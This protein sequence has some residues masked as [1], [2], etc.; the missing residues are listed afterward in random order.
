MNPG[1]SV[2]NKFVQDGST[3]MGQARNTV[4]DPTLNVH[5]AQLYFD[6]L[7]VPDNI[8]PNNLDSLPRTSETIAS[9]YQ[10]A[11]PTVVAQYVVDS[12]LY[13]E[14]YEHFVVLP[15]IQTD[16]TSGVECHVLR[17]RNAPFTS[18][19]EKSSAPRIR[20]SMEKHSM[21]LE[22]L[23]QAMELDDD[24]AMTPEGRMV[25][26]KYIETMSKDL[27]LSAQMAAMTAMLRCFD[28]KRAYVS[29]FGGG[30]ANGHGL[31]DHTSMFGIMF[32]EEKAFYRLAD[33]ARTMG[34]RQN[35]KPFTHAFMTYNTRTQA[36]LGDEFE[37][38]YYRRGPNNSRYLE[39]GTEAVQ[40]LP[41]NGIGIKIVTEPDYTLD[42]TEL[43]EHESYQLLENHVSV[44]HWNAILFDRLITDE[45]YPVPLKDMNLG[46]I[47]LEAGDGQ[48][49]VQSYTDLLRAMIIWQADGELREAAYNNL[50]SGGRAEAKAKE[51]GIPGIVNRDRPEDGALIDPFIVDG[52]NGVRS[53]T[54]YV[55][56]MH[57]AY[58]DS[59]VC[60]RIAGSARNAVM[61]KMTERDLTAMR[62]ALDFLEENYNTDPTSGYAARFATA[63]VFPTPRGKD[64]AGDDLPLDPA[65]MNMHGCFDIPSAATKD[66]IDAD[67]TLRGIFPGMSSMQHLRTIRDFATS[68][69]MNEWMGALDTF[70]A[71]GVGARFEAKIL[72]AVEGL[73]ALEKYARVEKGIWSSSRAP[74]AFFCSDALPVWMR[75]VASNNENDAFLQN[76]VIGLRYP[77]GITDN[78]V[79]P[80]VA[81]IPGAPAAVHLAQE[82]VSKTGAGGETLAILMLKALGIDE[83]LPAALTPAQKEGIV[84]NV[85]ENGRLNN[86]AR[87]AVFTPVDFVN[88]TFNDPNVVPIG[89]SGVKDLLKQ[90]VPGTGK[91]PINNVAEGSVIANTVAL[92]M[93]LLRR[94]VDDI[95]QSGNGE[96]LDEDAINATIVLAK[97]QIKKDGNDESQA[98][99][100]KRKFVHSDAA[101]ASDARRAAHP[102]RRTPGLP[103]GRMAGEVNTTLSFS[104]RGWA[105]FFSARGTADLSKNL[106]VLTPT[107]TTSPGNV[108]MTQQAYNTRMNEDE[109]RVANEY[110]AKASRAKYDIDTTRMGKFSGAAFSAPV[111][112]AHQAKRHRTS[113]SGMSSGARYVTL[114]QPRSAFPD[115]MSDSIRSTIRN[116]LMEDIDYDD[117][118][119]IFSEFASGRDALMVGTNSRIVQEAN[120]FFQYRW[121]SAVDRYGDDLVMLSQ[122]LLLLGQ[123]V[124]RDSFIQMAQ[125]GV[126]APISMLI[127]DPMIEMK[128]THAVFTS[129]GC[130]NIYYA[131]QDL[132]TGYDPRHKT[133]TAYMTIWLKAFVQLPQNVYIAENISFNGYIRGGDGSLVRSIYVDNGIDEEPLGGFDYDPT[134]PAERRASRFVL[135]IG[136]TTKL[137][138]IPNPLPLNG[139]FGG[140]GAMSGL[141]Q[142]VNEDHVS[143]DHGR[144]AFDS[145]MIVDEICKFSRLNDAA[146][147][148][149]MSVNDY[150]QRRDA[151]KGT[152]NMV[153]FQADQY[154]RNKATG[155]HKRRQLT[156]TG[157]LGQLCEGVTPILNGKAGMISKKLQLERE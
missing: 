15:P 61:E 40:T 65:S 84:V 71:A 104:P 111:A 141:G 75:G 151:V 123:R 66:L 72:Q 48:I 18:Q 78:V 60:H 69:S 96:V 88:D 122:H 51:L 83:M 32:K 7:G 101:S 31:D 100:A 132:S 153:C 127:V 9:M 89:F 102:S 91:A 94:K 107:D 68:A 135:P 17:F 2:L 118:V 109:T 28:N 90:R 116:H 143:G 112:H 55:G 42:G 157:H 39:G 154:G 76:I 73:A 120:M 53:A 16:K 67:T 128:M 133:L 152:F 14:S 24:F 6:R 77:T 29:K 155:S 47:N 5:P 35:A 43:G 20:H 110:L 30:Y 124:H 115:E 4:Q 150:F 26:D 147:H 149:V 114:G 11:T 79:Q 156:G 25:Y 86:Y 99:G 58:L 121:K 144:A 106:P 138:N 92:A 126:P 137:A 85:L 36:A 148:G 140:K 52:F 33:H 62:A 19:P 142:Y 1:G 13:N 37:T 12:S 93:L 64:V 46:Y 119:E 63:M 131:F 54:R 105:R 49:Q 22:R 98:A 21:T 103:D 80:D 97:M 125:M 74:N 146:S 145:A 27:I 50:T 113:E 130:G 139:S 136:A 117:N 41:G 38:E 44:G 8:D 95:K 45:E 59:D 70:F 10:H 82:A 23:G 134:A 57:T 3:H 34:M 56:N 108:W 81:L 129:A 87:D